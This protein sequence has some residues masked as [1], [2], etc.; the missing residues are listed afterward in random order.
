MAEKKLIAKTFLSTKKSYEKII[1]FE[2]L[3]F[4]FLDKFTALI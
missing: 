3:L 2:S 1:A 4:L